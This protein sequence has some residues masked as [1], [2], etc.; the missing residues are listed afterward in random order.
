METDKYEKLNKWLRFDL[1]KIDNIEI[2]GI[3]W[4]DAHD[5]CDA[6]ISSADYKGVPMTESELDDLNDNHNDFVHEQVLNWI[7]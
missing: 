4:N 6:F 5:F 3:D 2:E 7:Y 1:T